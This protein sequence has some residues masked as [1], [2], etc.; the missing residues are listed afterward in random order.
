MADIDRLD[1]PT[2]CHGSKADLKQMHDHLENL[3]QR[4][5]EASGDA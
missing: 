1:P 3:K 5:I 2:Y 4:G